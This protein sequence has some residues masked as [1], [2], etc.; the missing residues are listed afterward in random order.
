MREHLKVD[1]VS[2]HVGDSLSADIGETRG[3]RAAVIETAVIMLTHLLRV[4]A[5]IVFFE[6][7]DPHVSQSS[8]QRRP[9]RGAELTDAGLRRVE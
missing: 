8:S 6:R 2:V 4:L 3:E 1:A 5:A 7:D 9:A